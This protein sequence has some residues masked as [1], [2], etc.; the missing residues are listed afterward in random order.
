MIDAREIRECDRCG[1]PFHP[2]RV[3]QRFCS[4]HCHDQFYMEERR[5]ALPAYRMQQRG[6]LF[7]T[8]PLIR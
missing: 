1:S 8:L 2:V 4:T 7:L 5:S 6:S 3:L